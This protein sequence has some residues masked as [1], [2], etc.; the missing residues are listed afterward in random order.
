MAEQVILRAIVTKKHAAVARVNDGNY[1]ALASDA[2]RSNTEK[3]TKI[4]DA[5]QQYAKTRIGT[6]LDRFMVHR[7]PQ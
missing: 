3:I 2:I 4:I 6:R 5:K 1:A 7:P